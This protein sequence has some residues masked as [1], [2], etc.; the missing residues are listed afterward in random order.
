M[1]EIIVIN[2]TGQETA[3][4][5]RVCAYARVSSNSADQLNSYIAQ[6]D[7]Y[8]R[9]I[10]EN[11]EWEFVDVYADE[12]LT[13][14]RAD[15]RKDF[16]RMLRDCRKGKIDRILIKSISR[17][18]RNTRDCL[19]T[20]RELKAIGVSVRFEKEDIDTANIDSEMML[21]FFS[22]GAQEESISI[23]GNMRWSYRHRMKSGKFITCKAPFGYRLENGSLVIDEWEAEVVRYIFESYLNGKSKLEIAEEVTALGLK[24]R[25]GND[26]WKYFT[27][28]YILKNERY[29]GDALL[30][31]KCSTNV[32][33]FKK[34]V[35][36]GQQDKYYLKH[37]HPAIVTREQFETARELNAAR[38]VSEAALPQQYPLSKRIVCGECGS[39]FKRRVS[40]EKIYWVCYK[41]HRDSN[42]CPIKQIP[43]AD[44]HEAFQQM[45][46]KLK[47]GAP[48]ILRPMLNQL[49][50]LRDHTRSGN[51]RLS[52]VN[53]EM[54]ELNERNLVLGRLKSKG[55]IDSALFIE[56]TNEINQKINALRT[57]KRRL[58]EEDESCNVIYN[59]ERIMDTLER[60][61]EKLAGFDETVFDDII[62]KIIVVSEREIKLQLI[63][64]LK[65]TE[66]IAPTRRYKL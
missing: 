18:S 52:E 26:K 2:P 65:L 41:H 47:P 30:Q 48:L 22:N 61:P 27:I 55:Y 50:A 20:I 16:Q 43:E 19:E 37:S 11:K 31:K 32:L 13:G 34:I 4:K 15:K 35:N 53:K 29:I 39:V 60:G 42:V 51:T 63:N 57:I 6:V 45:Y 54:V 23:S 5:T 8:T 24:T 56:Q 58:L 12:G 44:I 36:K 64:G 9:F 33:P 3:K 49:L 21:A 14:L 17:F 46:N 62:D 1:T 38:T 10:N 25:D 40:K 7:H 59:T 28:D 66:Q